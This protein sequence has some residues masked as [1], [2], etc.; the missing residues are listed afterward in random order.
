MEKDIIPQSVL[1]QLNAPKEIEPFSFGELYDAL[2]IQPVSDPISLVF[3]ALIGAVFFCALISALICVL[4]AENK[5]KLR[6]FIKNATITLPALGILG[7]FVGVLVAVY[8]FDPDTIWESLQI[9]IQG[10]KIAFSTSIYGLASSIIIR[11]VSSFNSNEPIDIGPEDILHSLERVR[12][13]ANEHNKAIINAITGDAD[14]SLNTQLQ[15]MRKDLNDFATTVAE[16]NSSAL[17][18]ALKEAIADFNKNLIEGLGDN[19]ARLNDAVGKLLEWQDN[20]KRDMEE[21]RDTLDKAVK[22]ISETSESLQKIEEASRKIPENVAGLSELLTAMK[23]QIEN[24]EAHLQSFADIS[25]KA[26]D[27]MPRI[28]QILTSYTEGLEESIQSIM[29]QIT[30][31]VG[32][33]N[34]G[35]EALQSAYADT[36]EKISE[37]SEQITNASI[38]ISEGISTKTQEVLH[39]IS[40]ASNASIENAASLMESQTIASENIIK[41]TVSAVNE[42]TEKTAKTLIETVEQTSGQLAS[43]TSASLSSLREASET[44]VKESQKI[45]AEQKEATEGIMQTTVSAVNELAEKTAKI[46]IET[47]EQTSDQLANDTSVSLSSLREASEIAVMEARKIITEHKDATENMSETLKQQVTVISEGMSEV[48]ISA[49]Q[50]FVENFEKNLKEAGN[51]QE[52]SLTEF[53]EHMKIGISNSTKKL[54]EQMDKHLAALTK[55]M[56]ELLQQ[57]L[58]KFADRLGGIA[59]RLAEDYGPLTDQFRRVIELANEAQNKDK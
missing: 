29:T 11:I 51:R 32:T 44:A 16:A 21:I 5:P 13:E 19:F 52:K 49:N 15:H 25:E 2:I 9:I 48:M 26:S 10:L 7:T 23:V 36:G 3:I 31:Q 12:K 56:N 42:I 27:A 47:V 18:D 37:L 38:Q 39:Q 34:K 57:E 45:I 6:T 22:S 17:I 20:N 54:E 53:N 55:S 46:I 59:N 50:R 43:D 1:D 41:T 14:G 30:Q 28:E 35:F 33:Q 40:T 24:L 4:T 58:Q 8:K